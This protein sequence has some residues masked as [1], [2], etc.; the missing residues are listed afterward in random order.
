MRTVLIANRGEIAVR[1]ARACHEAGLAVVAVYSEADAGTPHVLAADRAVAIGPAAARESY[2]NVDALLAAARASGA[3]AVHPGYGFLAENAAF[4]R[5]VEAAG[6]V[7]IG[8]PPAAIATMG[9]KLTARTTVARAGVPVVPGSEL[10]LADAAA[11][12]RAAAAIGYPVLLKAAAGGGG[13]GMRTVAGEAE[14]APAL[15][16]AAREAEAAFAD[17]RVYLEKLLVRPRHVEVQVLGDA[18]GTLVHLGERECSVQRRHQKIVEETPCPVVNDRLRAAMTGAALSAARAVGYTSAGTVEFMLDESG[19]FYF[20]E[21]NTRLQV[22][23]PITEL[24]TGIDLVAAQLRIARG[25]PLGLTQADVRPRGH[26]IEVRL[27]AED[28]AA[29]FLPSAGPILGLREPAGPGVRVDS[30]LAAGGVVPVD[31]DPMLAKIAAWGTDRA[32]AI[33]RLVGALRETAVLGP[34]TNLAFLIDVLSHPAFAHGATHT[35]FLA[36]HLPRWQQTGTREAVA[37]I[38]AAI[39]LGRPAAAGSSGGA[40]ALPTPWETLGAWRLG[41]DA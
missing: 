31:Y 37:A 41:R 39:A 14:L 26:A 27:Y 25:E 20:L 32:Q 40:T 9:D 23:H 16:A 15:A 6:L 11:A 8:P 34:T 1:I 35:G 36:E 7:W 18:H 10:A 4:A 21:M 2:L 30:A 33:A 3:D 5:A 29:G 13:K 24:V 22:E 19:A 17:G 38:A 12:A 28:P